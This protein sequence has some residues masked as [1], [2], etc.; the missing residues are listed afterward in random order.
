MTS[1]VLPKLLFGQF[2]KQL[3]TGR[4]QTFFAKDFFALARKSGDS[5]VF[6]GSSDGAFTTRLLRFFVAFS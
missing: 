1:L 6:A 2:P 5:S 3:R 4:F